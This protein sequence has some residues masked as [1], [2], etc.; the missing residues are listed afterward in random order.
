MFIT[1]EGLD[2]SGKST[3]AV[4]VVERLRKDAVGDGTPAQVHFLREPGGTPISERIRDLLLDRANLEMT[5]LS[6]LLLFSASRAQLV[7]QVI[8]P[9]LKR[10]EIVVC[11]RYC[12][13]TIA[14]QGWGRGIDLTVVRAIIEASVGSTM[15]GLTL[16]IDI[17]VEEITRRKEAAGIGFDRMESAGREFYERV[18]NGFIDIAARE[19]HRM[20][21]IDGTRSI[22]DVH[23]QI[24]NAVQERAKFHVS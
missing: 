7:A 4:K 8:R 9:A 14:Y 3:Q 6:E 1:F 21:R 16:L 10:G 23:R 2:F 22:E 12:D 17:P 18:R 19:P 11:D 5:D 15:P 13:S 20:V 24:W